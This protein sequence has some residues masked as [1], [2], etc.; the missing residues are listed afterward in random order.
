MTTMGTG[1]LPSPSDHHGSPRRFVLL[2]GVDCRRVLL[3]QE[4]LTRE[5]LPAAQLVPWTSFLAGE[6]DLRE[7]VR[8]GDVVRIESPGRSWEVERLLMAAGAEE[9]D[10]DGCARLPA[11]QAREL[12]FERGR[13]W[14][15]RQ[16]YLGFRAALRAVEAQLLEA[17][18]HSL[19]NA[20]GD[21][22]RM[23][24][25]P[26]CQAL[27]AGGGVP[28][29]SFL[30]EPRSYDELVAA[31]ERGGC[32]RV[33]VK[34]AHGSS[35]S[36]VAAYRTDGRRH[37]AVT[38]VEVVRSRDETRLY[39]SR[40]LRVLTRQ[41]EIAELVDA[42]APHRIYAERW[43]PKA[44]IDGSTFD[45][46]LVVIGGRVRQL[47][48]RLSRG[49]MTNLHLLNRRGDP[50]AVRARMRV[51]AWEALLET[52]GRTAALFPGSLYAGL[53]VLVEPG[54]RR[55]AVAEVNAFGDLLP[56]VLCEGRETYD[57]EIAAVAGGRV[58]ACSTRES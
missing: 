7:V 3:F 26:A 20:V 58:E 51:E 30:G 50:E 24:D 44:G 40:R 36:G 33:F 11:R 57:W 35:A 47:L 2:G 45:L 23:F 15:P 37:Q 28:V 41:A 39:N 54:F 43:V 14:Y 42:L 16:W 4:A 56:G 46:R 6:M 5:R 53:D 8:P 55:H 10:L 38:T 29:P 12:A 9:R 48:P 31:M 1:T 18:D 32:R 17:P 22:V 25:K 21:I 27:L 49:P 34:L 13:I 19:M 52:A